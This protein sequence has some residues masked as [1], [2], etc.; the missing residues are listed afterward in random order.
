MGENK[1]KNRIEELTE[2]ERYRKRLNTQKKI[3]SVGGIALM[4]LVSV[5]G[6]LAL[7]MLGGL[8]IFGGFGEKDQKNSLFPL[9]ISGGLVRQIES[10]G[11]DVALC[12]QGEML[13]L[14]NKGEEQQRF[15]HGMGSPVLKTQ[16]GRALLY[17]QGGERFEVFSSTKKLYSGNAG[18]NIHAA[19]IIADGTVAI[20]ASTAKYTTELSVYGSGYRQIG[21][22]W[23]SASQVT[24]LTLSPDGRQTAIAC[25]SV[26]N[27]GI[28]STL[29]LLDVNN[30][31]ELQKVSI[32]DEMVVN[33]SFKGN[34]INILTDRSIKQIDFSGRIRG[35]YP[36]DGRQALRYA[37]ADES[38]TVV[39]LGNQRYLRESE[40]VLVDASAKQAAALQA[41]DE[42]SIL[43]ADENGFSVLSQGSIWRYDHTGTALSSLTAP[44]VIKYLSLGTDVFTVTYEELQKHSIRG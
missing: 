23:T 26:E 11:W 15:S 40:I 29:Y 35:D 43:R 42:V 36:F 2:F 41:D 19:S 31:K 3:R 6:I 37:D 16:S 24:A 5:A 9:K 32:P 28:V 13:V 10:M 27:G 33:I 38:G 12:S 7:A 34:S 44:D 18:G 22:A 25:V 20:A 14:N 1:K 30:A 4:A 21:S 8:D 17:D 39:L